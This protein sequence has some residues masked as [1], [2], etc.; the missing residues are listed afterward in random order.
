MTAVALPAPAWRGWPAA[1]LVAAALVLTLWSAAA[2]LP[3]GLWLAAAWAPDLT[4]PG[5]LLFRHAFLPRLAVSWLAGAAL[6]LA[7]TIFQQVLRNPLAE[8]TTLGT[9]AGAGLALAAAGLYA[10]ALLAQGREAVALAGAALATAAVF[11]LA[12]RR[13]APVTL[14]LA[15]LV[16]SL[17]CG[18]A[19]A[20]LVLLHREY[21]T[22]LF[23]WQSGSLV[24]TGDATALS[25]LPRLAA[26]GVL[27]A[28][29]ARPLALLELEDAGAAGL[30][31]SPARTRLA[32]LA[33]AV[34]LSAAVVAAVGVIGFV[35][36]AAPAAARLCGA[37][38]LR[39]RMAVAPLAGAL[40]L[41]LAD[42]LALHAPFA[43][44]IP[45]GTVTALLGAPLLLALLPRLRL[46]GTSAAPA[47]PLRDRTGRPGLRL[48]LGLAL[49]LAAAAVALL[50]GRNADGW[51]WATNLSALLPLRAPRVATALAAGAVLGM[52]GTLLQRMT[53]N[54][55]AAPEMLG[56]SAGASTGVVLLL[57]AVPGFDRGATL[58]AAAAGALATLAV[59][60]LIARR[61]SAAPERLLLAGVALATMFSGLAAV[62]LA[63]DDPR[64]DRLLAW[65]SGSTYHA[66][67]PEAAVAAMAA[68]AMLALAPLTARWLEIL[69]LGPTPARALGLDPARARLA[70][71][72]LV[73]LPVAAAT[74]AI[75]PLS[76]V[77]LMA[78]HMARLA[79]FRRALP[80]LLASALAGALIL[81]VADWLGRTLIFPWQVPAGL[82]ATF[83]GGPYLLWLLRR[84]G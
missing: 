26:A 37:R 82:L 15:G 8:P 49:L 22:E 52:A 68:V 80:Q 84:G 27:A 10:P 43:E 51:G 31:L 24:Q 44:E 74:L 13:L 63:G 60:L 7:G 69:P 38:T 30:G 17:T 2:L 34:G 55:M 83:I 3:P 65:M 21:M 32:G 11:G 64:V 16:V 45:A 81:L 9:S 29:L 58:A 36:L 6:G 59:L 70:L 50:F 46:A 54:P 25:L 14:I 5:Q 19:G 77:G 71:L 56:I 76:F 75:G 18:S 40:L 72:P 1:L 4:D 39:Q 62:V 12:G 79:G 61:P 48:T 20:L 28:L 33:V 78:P 41:W 23:V 53:G 35:G 66:G 67:L 42:Q 57:L 47:A 73:A